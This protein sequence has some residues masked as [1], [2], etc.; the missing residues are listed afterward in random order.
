MPAREF[1]LPDLG[2]GLEEAEI[3]HWLVSEG[4]VVA[5][6]Q[7]LVEVETAKATVEVPS[8]FAGTIVKL[9]ADEGETLKVGAPLV[10]FEIE[11]PPREGAPSGA[12]EAATRTK[13]RPSQPSPASAAQYMA[14]PSGASSVAA[15]LATPAVRKLARDFGVDLDSVEGTGPGDRITREDVERAAKAG[16]EA[17]E[18]A[19]ISMIRRT[20]AEN[21]TR[22]VR[23]IP[24]V[25]AFRTLDCTALEA[26]RRGLG[27]SPLPIVVRALAEI[28]KEHRALNA[29]YMGD[30]GQIWLHRR[31]HVGIATDT[32]RGLLVPVVRDA[33]EGTIGH[34]A[35]EIERLAAA[36]RDG[37]IRI[38]EL[39]G[40]TI[41]VTNT[42]SY[43]SEFGTP[44]INP[45]QSA[46]LGL[47]VIEPRALVIDGQVVAR[48][49]CTLSL[50]FDHRLLDGATAGRAF[51]D[52]V[53]LLESRDQ[54]E[55][56]PT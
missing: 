12:P 53:S 28:C 19:P 6:N 43:G 29:S 40:G 18:V 7:P 10:T 44:I 1:L 55:A 20:I 54:L 17:V 42:G 52:L 45:P 49:A 24:H 41:T 50:A 46:I 13:D 3:G 27:V 37:S 47:G 51:G 33:A 39:N 21:L 15:P 23:Q 31:V 56:L 11:E 22:A 25:T 38:Q 4:D 9:H 34:I 5:L 30:R 32:E 36:A 26:F 8:P 48:P 14:A 35:A 2:E 16:P